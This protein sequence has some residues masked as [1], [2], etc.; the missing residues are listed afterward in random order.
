MPGR[1]WT[2]KE[3]NYLIKN[4]GKIPAKK[5]AE[6]LSKSEAAIKAYAGRMG[7]NSNI[8]VSN[9]EKTMFEKERHLCWK[10]KHAVNKPV[11]VRIVNG[12]PKMVGK[13]PWA[14]HLEPVKG[15]KTE[16]VGMR[17]VQSGMNIKKKE[18]FKII[19]CPL[20]EVG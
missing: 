11:G 18:F 7:L 13:C 10:C 6:K 14:D 3:K 2:K 4:Y 1:K 8:E 12:K 16:S 15:W 9:W 19:K 5:I 20:Y 17:S